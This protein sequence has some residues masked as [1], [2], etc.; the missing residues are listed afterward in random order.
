MQPFR[1]T[2]ACICLPIASSVIKDQTAAETPSNG[3]EVFPWQAIAVIV[4]VAAFVAVL[5]GL[6]KLYAKLDR[7]S[8]SGPKPGA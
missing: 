4:A 8:K 6:Y 3:F 7:W 5:F 1:I 2:F